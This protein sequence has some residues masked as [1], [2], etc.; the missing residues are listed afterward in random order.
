MECARERSGSCRRQRSQFILLIIT[1][2]TWYSELALLH[3][4]WAMQFCIWHP[5]FS[6][7]NDCGVKNFT[8]EDSD[9][10]PQYLDMKTHT[11]YEFPSYEGKV[12]TSSLAYNRRKIRYKRPLDRK[13]QFINYER[14]ARK[15][16]VGEISTHSYFEGDGI[17]PIRT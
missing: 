2:S 10:E 13:G 17:I 7:R 4:L 15:R 16:G 8:T 1:C 12:K 11:A 6:D 14:V 3:F 9:N 5:K